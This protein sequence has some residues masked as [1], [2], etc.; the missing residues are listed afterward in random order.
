MLTFNEFCVAVQDCIRDALPEKY[1]NARIELYTVEKMNGVKKTG[2]I[3][4]SANEGMHPVIYLEEFYQEF[5]SGALMSEVCKT[6]SEIYEKNMERSFDMERFDF[7]EWNQVKDK[8]SM[9][10]INY[11]ENRNLLSGVPFKQVDDLAVVY[12]ID[13][14]IKDDLL[15]QASMMIRNEHMEL[16]GITKEELFEVAYTNT[17]VLYPPLLMCMDTPEVLFLGAEN[18]LEG[19][20]KKGQGFMYILTNKEKSYGA[21]SLLYPEVMEQAKGII[22]E[23]FYILPSSQHETIL[24]PKSIEDARNLGIMVREVNVNEVEREEVLSDHVYEFNFSE[25]QIQSVKESMIK[26]REVVR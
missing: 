21:T 2:L 20:S 8:V 25:K 12:R 7:R 16:Y 11:K 26:Q 1:V 10:L 19:G 3:I 13:V 6:I 15:G 9:K 17:K 5:Q 22:G 23:D 14:P 24:V 18:L 4:N